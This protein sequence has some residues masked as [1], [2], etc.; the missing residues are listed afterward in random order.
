MAILVDEKSKVVVQG[1][2]GREGM[3]RTRL[4]KD[5]GTDVV[6]G[7]TPGKEEEMSSAFL[8]MTR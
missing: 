1:I 6:A 5:Y 2:T 8:C 4:M 7:I 3:V